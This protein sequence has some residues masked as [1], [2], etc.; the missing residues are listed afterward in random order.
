MVSILLD[1]KKSSLLC[2]IGGVSADSLKYGVPQGSVAGPVNFTCYTEDVEVVISDF[3]VRH[4]LYAD[5][6]QLLAKTLPQHLDS[7]RQ[8]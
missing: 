8:E 6:M 2:W 1:A 4:H 7:C 5:D 3:Q